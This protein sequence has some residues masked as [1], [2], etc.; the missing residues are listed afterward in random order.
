MDFQEGETITPFLDAEDVEIVKPDSATVEVV[1]P[2]LVTAEIV[3]SVVRKTPI[4]RAEAFVSTSGERRV[5]IYAEG[6]VILKFIGHFEV[7]RN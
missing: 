5:F 3:N 2:D 6:G 1:R 7:S 4:T